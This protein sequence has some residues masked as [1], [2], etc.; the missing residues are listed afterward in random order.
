[1]QKSLLLTLFIIGQISLFG[2]FSPLPI[3][4]STQAHSSLFTNQNQVAVDHETNSIVFVHTQN[5]N[6]YGGGMEQQ[7]FLRYDLSTDGG[8]SFTTDIGPVISTSTLSRPQVVLRND[9]GWGIADSIR[10]VFLGSRVSQYQ[11][12]PFTINQFHLSSSMGMLNNLAF[13]YSEHSPSNLPFEL[14]S[15]TSSAEGV[16]WTASIEGLAKQ[17]KILK[18]VHQVANDSI[19]WEA[20][21]VYNFATP[22][23]DSKQGNI[24]VEFYKSGNKYGWFS[25]L[26]NITG[27]DDES[28]LPILSYTSNSGNSWSELIEVDLQNADYNGNLN[29]ELNIQQGEHITCS[30]ESDLI[31]DVYGNPHL[32]VIIGKSNTDFE[33]QPGP[34]IIADLTTTDNG[35]NWSLRKID[36]IYTWETNFGFQNGTIEQYNFPQ[37]SRSEDGS[38]IFYSWVDSDTTVIGSTTDNL[39]PNLRVSGYR[40]DD[41]A[42][43]CVKRISDGD[44]IW[45]GRIVTPTMSSEVLSDRKTSPTYELPIV[46]SEVVNHDV[47]DQVNYH[48]FGNDIHFSETEF[49]PASRASEI[50]CSCKPS[51]EINGLNN[52][53]YKSMESIIVNSMLLLD[54][55][56][57]VFLQAQEEVE[58][59]EATVNE[60][61]TFQVVM[62]NCD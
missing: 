4:S 52:G 8:T 18:G 35:Q 26:G 2:Q 44:F 21:K 38:H 53:L 10:S 36:N 42:V 1:M 49:Y 30:P 37:I 17:I 59:H 56:N 29:I 33:F 31:V 15:L 60:D 41:N 5:T 61:A 34:M 57:Q 24:A 28:I 39:A 54:I 62:K 25:M 6:L 19:I 3:G 55:E 45:E 43:T 27:S 16:Y 51:I 58:I 7:T 12:G 40:I 47:Q 11:N 46:V 50:N 13:P 23:S 20:N 22:S 14:G 9:G 32:L 48:Y